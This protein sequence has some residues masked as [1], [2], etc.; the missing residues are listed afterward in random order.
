MVIWPRV[1]RHPAFWTSAFWSGWPQTSD[2]IISV[3]LKWLLKFYV[4]MITTETS[5][6]L[7]GREVLQSRPVIPAFSSSSTLGF[8]G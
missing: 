2:S 4:A 7:S 6:R 5:S 3:V 1:W 8:R